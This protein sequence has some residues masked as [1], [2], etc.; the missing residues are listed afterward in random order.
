MNVYYIPRKRIKLTKRALK[1][2]IL[3]LEETPLRLTPYWTN[4][5]I[6]KAFLYV[7]E[8]EKLHKMGSKKE[9][10]VIDIIISRK[11]NSTLYF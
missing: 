1:E 3:P 11:L 4:I 10:L 9:E 2:K 8:P 6:F 5:D 7:E